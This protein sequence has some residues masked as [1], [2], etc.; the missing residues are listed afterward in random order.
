MAGALTS[1]KEIVLP[2]YAERFAAAGFVTLAFDYRFLGASGGEPRSQIFPWEQVEDIRNAISWLSYRPEV[3]PERIGGWG[4]SLGGAHM[5][6]LP[7]FDRRLKA[8]VATVPSVATTENLMLWMGREAI[9]QMLGFLNRDRTSRYKSGEVTYMKAVSD[10]SEQAL[11]PSPEAASYY[12]EA[13]RTIAPNWRNQVTVESL[14]KMMEHDPTYA[15]HLISP[16]PLLVVVAENDQAL[17]TPLTIKAFE[18][19]GDPKRLVNLPCGHTDVYD[20][21][22]WVSQSADAAVDWYKQHLG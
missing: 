21:E 11:M 17:P 16:T 5:L 15:I 10:G 20:K 8:V 18:R 4:V 7:A 22:P 2:L 1:V 9:G 19:A 6:Y 13:N 14:E 3:D 12:L